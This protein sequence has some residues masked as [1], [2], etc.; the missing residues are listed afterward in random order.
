MATGDPELLQLVLER[1]DFQRYSS[2]MAGIPQLLQRLKEAP[3]F[4]VEMKWEFT[5]WG[6]MF[7]YKYVCSLYRCIPVP[8]VSRMCPSDTYK[9]YKQGSN[10]R[11][12]TTLLGFDHTNWQ[13]G[14][15]SYVFQGHSKYF[16]GCFFCVFKKLLVQ[17]SHSY[18][19]S[20]TRGTYLYLSSEEFQKWG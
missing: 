8:L 10:V 16:I 12:D 20:V 11:I 3:D 7:L 9:V 1:R 6:K 19:S 15:R 5:S 14:S 4:Y 18:S 2:R 17:H 13:T